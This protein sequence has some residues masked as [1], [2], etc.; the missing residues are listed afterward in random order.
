MKAN[1]SNIYIIRECLLIYCGDNINLLLCWLH[2]NLSQV[3]WLT[4]IKEVKKMNAYPI[5]ER[6]TLVMTISEPVCE[7]YVEK[8]GDN[9]HILLLFYV[10]NGFTTKTTNRLFTYTI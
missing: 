3:I 9:I 8:C 1:Y 10:L 4:N 6:N 7:S 2:V 5:Y